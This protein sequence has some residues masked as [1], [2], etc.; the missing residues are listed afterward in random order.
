M[1]EKILFQVIQRRGAV[2]MITLLLSLV[3]AYSL[4]LLPID[5]VP[6]IK[7]GRAHV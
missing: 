7:I 6:D 5:A 2:I 3:G 1:F 4:T